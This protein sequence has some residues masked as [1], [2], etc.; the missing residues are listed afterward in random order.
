MT[1]FLIRSAHASG[2]RPDLMAILFIRDSSSR[3][4]TVYKLPRRR[5]AP[6][7]FVAVSSD[8]RVRNVNV[9]HMPEPVSEVPAADVPCRLRFRPPRLSS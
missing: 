3:P 1:A 5:P 7:R 2:P 8:E 6:G 9:S 4:P